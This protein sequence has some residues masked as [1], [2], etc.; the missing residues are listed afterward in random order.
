MRISQQKLPPS[1]SPLKSSSLSSSPSSICDIW[2]IPPTTN[3]TMK[4]KRYAR[5]KLLACAICTLSPYGH[6][7]MKKLE[8]LT[9]KKEPMKAVPNVLIILLSLVPT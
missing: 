7:P 9:V 2:K 6:P 3:R 4:A 1:S 5:M 8:P